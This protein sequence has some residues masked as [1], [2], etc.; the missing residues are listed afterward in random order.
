M[1]D[2]YKPALATVFMSLKQD[3]SAISEILCEKDIDRNDPVIESW[4]KS[5]NHKKTYS[6][7]SYKAIIVDSP[8]R[9]G[10][11]NIGKIKCTFK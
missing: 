7:R 11:L 3:R 1:S 9:F 4:I 10:A 2:G 5:R 8:V 6:K